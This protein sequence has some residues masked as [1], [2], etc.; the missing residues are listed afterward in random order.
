MLFA[1][2]TPIDWTNHFSEFEFVADNLSPLN[3]AVERLIVHLKL[4]ETMRRL[5]SVRIVF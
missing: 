5:R 3:L 1:V 4:A 2:E